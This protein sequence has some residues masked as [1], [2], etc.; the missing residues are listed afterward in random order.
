MGYRT[1]T[2]KVTVGNERGSKII[3]RLKADSKSLDE[4]VVMGKS[5]ARKIREQAMPI[6]VISM[7]QIQG[8]VNNVQDVLAKQPVSPCG[9]WE[10][11]A[12]LLV[13]PYEGWKGNALGF[14]LTDSR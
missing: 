7:S 2:R 5:E 10:E 13:F 4:V 3:I 14:S 11:W 1:Q 12:V 9:Q 6:S 8:T